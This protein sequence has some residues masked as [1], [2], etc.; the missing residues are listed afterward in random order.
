MLTKPAAEFDTQFGEVAQQ[1]VHGSYK[2][3]LAC[4]K[5]TAAVAAAAA[6]KPRRALVLPRFGKAVPV[7]LPSVV[8][9]P[10]QVS[11]CDQALSFLEGGL[12][13]PTCRT[14][15]HPLRS[16][17]VTTA[18]DR[19]NCS[20]HAQPPLDQ[21]Q[22]DSS[23]PPKASSKADGLKL[24]SADGAVRQLASHKALST[25]TPSAAEEAAPDSSAHAPVAKKRKSSYLPKSKAATKRKCLPSAGNALSRQVRTSQSAAPQEED[26]SAQTQSRVALPGTASKKPVA[27][28]SKPPL[29][30]P[31]VLTST[32]ATLAPITTEAANRF[33]AGLN[34]TFPSDSWGVTS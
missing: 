19:P 17:R 30:L 12:P 2:R 31:A 1:T 14:V 21:L 23:S 32:L 34:G 3:T 7:T 10:S 5:T 8:A 28:V 18:D 9:T 6:V 15:T 11:G 20:K 29:R 26:R 33:P 24:P 13:Y 4:A 16:T 22:A 25:E 27:S